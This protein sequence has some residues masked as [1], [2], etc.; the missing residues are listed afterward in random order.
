MNGSQAPS[1]GVRFL[2]R[3]TT[4]I[5]I[6][7]AAISLIKKPP[8]SGQVAFKLCKM[9]VAGKCESGKVFTG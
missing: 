4:K 1:G 2:Q 9:T 3:F 7:E 5:K 6:A 8:N